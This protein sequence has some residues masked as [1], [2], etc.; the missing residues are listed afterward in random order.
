VVV[1][2]Y[3][4]FVEKLEWSCARCPPTCLLRRD[5][6]LLRESTLR[7]AFMRDYEPCSR[8]RPP[9]SP[10]RARRRVTTCDLLGRV[11]D[12]LDDRGTVGHVGMT[13]WTNPVLNG[14]SFGMLL[15]LLARPV[16]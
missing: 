8:G 16:A 5:H 13:F 4:A 10:A 9:P 6:Q 12:M 1:T 14:L 3:S 2:R 7:D 15:F 11:A